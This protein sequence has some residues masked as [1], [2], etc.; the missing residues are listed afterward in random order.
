MKT[1]C[2]ETD[3]ASSRWTRHEVVRGS[4]GKNLVSPMLNE[5]KKRFGDGIK[6]RNET[7]CM[8]AARLEAA[9]RDRGTPQVDNLRRDAPRSSFRQ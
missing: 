3:V 1:G 7:F 4:T 6:K 9:P 8:K 2:M 5:I